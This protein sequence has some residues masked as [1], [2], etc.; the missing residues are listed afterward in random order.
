MNTTTRIL[1]TLTAALIAIFASAPTVHAQ[2]FKVIVNSAVGA[3][4]IT[5]AALSKVFLKQTTK[6]PDGTAVTAVYQGKASP[7]REAFDKAVLGKTVA[8]VETFW[9]QQIFSGKDVPPAV[10]ASD[11]EVISFVKST[12]GGIGYVSAG[13][14]VAGVKVLAVK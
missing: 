1:S 4:D 14:A 7:T 3:S 10:K 13:A 5:T 6:L 11:D 12:P 9:Q 8:G 2:G